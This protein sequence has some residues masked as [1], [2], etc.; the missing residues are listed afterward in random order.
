MADR[1]YKEKHR[2]AVRKQNATNRFRGEA[3][4]VPGRRWWRE[5]AVMA[6]AVGRALRPKGDG[7]DKRNVPTKKGAANAAP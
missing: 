4:R 2:Q 5:G 6:V 7:R 1:K 3:A